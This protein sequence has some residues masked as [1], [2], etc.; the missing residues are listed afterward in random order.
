[1]K[2]KHVT[3]RRI[4]RTRTR[5]KFHHKVI[6]FFK[7]DGG[8]YVIFVLATVMAGAFAL[9]GGILP[10]LN[11]TP[12]A[13]AQVTIDPNSAKS[14]SQ[15]SLQLVDIKVKPTDTPTPTPT[16]V[17]SATPTKGVTPTPQACFDKIAL[18]LVLDVS[19]SMN[20]QDKIVQLN[21]AMKD[22][23]GQLKDNTVVGA[24]TFAGLTSFPNT[25]G[26]ITQ[27]PF[28][29]YKD[30]K[31]LVSNKLTKLTAYN[32]SDADGTYMRN[33][34]QRSLDNLNADE[35]TYTKQ[36]YKFVTIVF[37]DGVPET[38]VWDDDCV[39]Y[40]L[41]SNPVCFARK[42]DPRI[43]PNLTTSMKNAVSKVYSVGIYSGTRE[44]QPVIY[45]EAKLLLSAIAS[46]STYA[47]NSNNPSAIDSMFKDV[48]NS[49]CD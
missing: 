49:V 28:T 38:Q 30:N 9:S 5:R 43:S 46:K 24:V 44:T 33:A 36:G 47:K 11:Q 4:H 25:G 26:S 37:T 17:P 1:M 41:G 22:L 45:N 13:S 35:A 29:R 19:A 34:F 16:L 27:L 23:V 39:V 40:V 20:N 42:Q 7:G 8:I 15:S 18:N 12:P 3:R 2:K 21:T 31:S 10:N 48:L 32:G 14:S 6:S